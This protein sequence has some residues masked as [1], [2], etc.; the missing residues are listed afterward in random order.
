MIFNS[1]SKT[2]AYY[3]FV[4][5]DGKIIVPSTDVILTDDRSGFISIKL[6]GTRKTIG[7]LR[8]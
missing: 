6:I 1:Y 5:D 8:K 2:S 7:L 3:I 4:G